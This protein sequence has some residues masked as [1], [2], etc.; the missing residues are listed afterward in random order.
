MHTCTQCSAPFVSELGSKPYL[1]LHIYLG[2]RTH[3]FMLS[4]NVSVLPR[5]TRGYMQL[6]LARERNVG[7]DS[8]AA[9]VGSFR[10]GGGVELWLDQQGALL[11]TL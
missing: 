3:Y 6:C 9:A 5:I 1:N 11:L 7:F 2:T 4:V 10:H 8:A